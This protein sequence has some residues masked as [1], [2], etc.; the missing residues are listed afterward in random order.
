MAKSKKAGHV[1][2]DESANWL[3][4]KWIYKLKDR[5]ADGG[6]T[7]EQQLNNIYLIVKGHLYDR[8]LIE[9]RE[10]NETYKIVHHKWLPNETKGTY[11][12]EVYLYPPVKRKGGGGSG[13]VTPPSPT[14]PPKM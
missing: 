3:D 6:P 12:L 13:S 11:Q 2:N 4:E 10:G 9:K 5:S 7:I 1:S 8:N 14:P